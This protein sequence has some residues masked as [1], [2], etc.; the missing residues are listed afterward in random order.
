MGLSRT[1]I[2]IEH[3]RRWRFATGCA[4]GRYGN[5]EAALARGFDLAACECADAQ[6][7]IVANEDPHSTETGGVVYLRG[8]EADCSGCGRP[9]A[10]VIVTFW[11]WFSLR[12]S[13]SPTSA[14]S[15][16]SPFWMMRNIGSPRQVQGPLRYPR[17][18]LSGGSRCVYG[19]ADLCPG[20]TPIESRR[21][22]SNW[23]FSASQP[24]VHL[25]PL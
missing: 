15:S 2:S 12:T 20:Q 25:V 16:I 10:M 19:R 9:S 23:T 21:A 8:D 14:S 17:C 7:A 4:N 5:R 24:S 18:V 22:A 1:V 13:D 3:E 6:S 11:S